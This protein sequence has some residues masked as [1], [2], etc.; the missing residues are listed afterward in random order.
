[1]NSCLILVESPLQLLN[2]YEALHHYK[3]EKAIIFLRYSRLT[4]NDAQLE[5]LL[6]VLDFSRV[7]I[8]KIYVSP[9]RKGI[10]DIFNIVKSVFYSCLIR[11]RLSRVLLGNFD[12]GYFKLILRFLKSKIIL[13]DDG[14]KSLR[15][16]KELKDNIDIEFFTSY[17]VA[18]KNNGNVINNQYLMTKN[19]VEKDLFKKPLVLFLGSGMAEIDI[20]TED[21]YLFLIEKIS[22]YYV[23]QGLK[24]IYIPHRAESSGKLELISNIDGV[25]LKYCDY[26]VE[27]FGF[28]N[29]FSPF[30]VSSFCSSAIVTMKN[31]YGYSVECF[32]F[33][34]KGHEDEMELDGLYSHYKS[35]G[36]KVNFL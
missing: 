22:K 5:K 26:P 16:H 23:S 33:D 28:F 2:A 32:G 36:I 9:T 19:L 7:K 13:L 20:V 11:A 12:S 34:Y 3:F 14:N 18:E 15:L 35:L 10:S 24:V 25:E 27:L 31:V 17:E 1:M 29:D 4:R 30:V 21:Y 8:H 6:S